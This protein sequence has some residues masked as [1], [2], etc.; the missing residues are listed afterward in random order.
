LTGKASWTPTAVP[1]P[2][3]NFTEPISRKGRASCAF[4]VPRTARGK[5]LAVT[6]VLTKEGETL[7]KVFSKKIR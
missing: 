1:S 7:R 3:P 4:A 6:I 5:T 2:L